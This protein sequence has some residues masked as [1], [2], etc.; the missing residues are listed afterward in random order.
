MGGL[1]PYAQRLLRRIVEPA[2]LIEVSAADAFEFACNAVELD[3]AIVVHAASR[4]LR[5]R[6]QDAGYRVFSSDLGK[7]VERGGGAKR[8]TLKLDDGPAAAGAAA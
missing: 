7:F 1:M 4:G 5:E 2:Y 8:M 6:L 3:D